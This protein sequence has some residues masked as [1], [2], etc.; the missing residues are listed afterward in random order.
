[1]EA[2][3]APAAPVTQEEDDLEKE[4]RAALKAAGRDKPVVH[5]TFGTPLPGSGGSASD[6]GVSAP[7]SAP[8]GALGTD[9]AM[10]LGTVS[11]E[12]LHSG[13]PRLAK[14]M[15]QRIGAFWLTSF[16][17]ILTRGS[18]QARKAGLGQVYLSLDTPSLVP[19]ATDVRPDYTQYV[20]EK[21]LVQILAA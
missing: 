19:S 5:Q 7:T 21:A 13:G 6:A 9:F 2:A 3:Y 1:M 18:Y 12:V 14:E 8:A 11:S 17:R 20:L 15:A 10:S 4:L 16:C